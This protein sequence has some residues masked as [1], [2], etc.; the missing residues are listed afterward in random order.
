MNEKKKEV[1]EEQKTSDVKGQRIPKRRCKEEFHISHRIRKSET[2]KKQGE[3]YESSQKKR[4]G[5][6][7]ISKDKINFR[8]FNRNTRNSHLKKG[9]KN[10]TN[11]FQ[12]IGEVSRT[13]KPRSLYASKLLFKYEAMI[14]IFLGIK[15]LRLSQ[16]DQTEDRFV[17]NTSIREQKIPGDGVRCIESSSQ[18]P[19]YIF[20]LP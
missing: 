13:I 10:K 6:A 11:I 9:M 12:N 19:Q 4:T 18:I 20:M 8:C 15:T 5:P 7:L 1:E 2:I 16:K 17:L 3:N 14:K